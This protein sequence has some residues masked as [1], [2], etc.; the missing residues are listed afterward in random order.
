VADWIERQ[1]RVDL[2][3]T[4]L[5]HAVK[6]VYNLPIFKYSRTCL[7]FGIPTTVSAKLWASLQVNVETAAELTMT[8]YLGD[9]NSFKRSNVRFRNKGDITALINLVTHAELRF[10]SI[11]TEL[12]GQHLAHLA[13]TRVFQ[14]LAEFSCAYQLGMYRSNRC[15]RADTGN[16]YYG[17]SIQGPG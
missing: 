8:G 9:P 15:Q 12:L 11:S 3:W 10:G 13:L 17:A 14:T 1:R 5:Q 4:A 16:S 2:E 6:E 7:I